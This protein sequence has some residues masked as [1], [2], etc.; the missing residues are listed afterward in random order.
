MHRQS[1]TWHEEYD[2]W[3][4]RSLERPSNK[5]SALKNDII[6]LLVGPH[7]YQNSNEASRLQPVKCLHSPLT[8]A[9]PTVHTLSSYP[10]FGF[11]ALLD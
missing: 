2:R 9:A 4:N 1:R 5:V 11:F 8:V 10:T 7:P 3:G 6:G